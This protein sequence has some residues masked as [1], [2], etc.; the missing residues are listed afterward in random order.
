MR[1]RP[2]RKWIALTALLAAVCLFP[3]CMGTE[4]FVQTVFMSSDV[5]GAFVISPEDHRC[6]YEDAALLAESGSL[7]CYYD[8]RTGSVGLC[9]PAREPVWSALPSYPNRTAAV[10]AAEAFNG[11]ATYELNSQDH[12]AAFGAVS[13]TADGDGVTVTYVMADKEATALKSPEEL[14]AGDVCVSIPVRYAFR[15]GRLTVSVDMADVVCAPGLILCNISLLPSWGAIDHENESARSAVPAA[16]TT[17]EETDAAQGAVPANAAEAETLP[18][19]KETTVPAQET[20]V[21]AQAEAS[22]P[23]ENDPADFI[24]LPDGCGAAAYTEDTSA[25]YPELDFCVYGSD[26]PLGRQASL[27]AFGIKKGGRAF[28]C[29]VTEGEELAV[30]R[31]LRQS[32]SPGEK[33]YMV[34]ARYQVTPVSNDDGEMAYGLTYTG[35]LSQTYSFVSGGDACCAGMA[36]AAREML[37]HA[38]KLSSVTV[39]EDAYPVNV[40]LTGSVD[41]K[42]ETLLTDYEQAEAVLSLLRAKGIEKVNLSLNGFL[43]GGLMNHSASSVSMLSSAGTGRQLDSLCDYAVKQGYDIYLGCDLLTAGSALSVSRDLSGKKRSY[44]EL[45]PFAGVGSAQYLKKYVGWSA[46]PENA[47]GFLTAMEDTGFTGFTLC[48]LY[49][50]V[51]ADYT[52]RAYDRTAVSARLS[53]IAA[54]YSTLKKLWVNGAG[55]NTLKCADVITGVPFGAAAGETEQYR[56]VPFLQMILHGSCVYSGEAVASA[57]A[58]RLSLLKT[59]EFGGVPYFSWVGSS[60]SDRCYEELLNAAAEFCAR[61]G[62]ELR[63]LAGARITDNYEV[64]HGLMCTEYDSGAKVYVNYNYYSA[65]VG[66]ITVGPYDFVR[67]N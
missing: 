27:G 20:T 13:A 61:A 55:L 44:T 18:D 47:S 28:V 65:T 52:S 30:I 7:A 29:V 24:L 50:G 8:E 31:T 1:F 67:I 19:A 23:A 41:G 33:P 11:T 3:S 42:K 59:V 17:A 60:R 15:N 37:I 53:E 62:T 22:A 57:S 40:A 49:R 35:T 16:E 12:A 6:S 48:D 66:E 43:S 56:A 25:P 21:P 4:N 2:S 58:E 36:A 63:G 51:S 32:D 9:G 38:G 5:R 39:A 46:I 45:N 34:Y 26:D 10:V 64:S 14:K 54:S